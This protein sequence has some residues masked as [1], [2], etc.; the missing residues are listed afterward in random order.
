MALRPRADALPG[1]LPPP[2]FH[3]RFQAFCTG[4]L[5]LRFR[6]MGDEFVTKFPL[7]PRHLPI[8]SYAS[9][10]PASRFRGKIH[11]GSEMPV[12]TNQANPKRC[13][14]LFRNGQM[15]AL[16]APLAHPRFPCHPAPPPPRSTAPA[17]NPSAAAKPIAHL[18]TGIQSVKAPARFPH[19]QSKIHTA[20]TKQP[21]IFPNPTSNTQHPKFQTSSHSA[22][23]GKS[24]RRF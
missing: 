11:K 22:P 12:P 8:H 5:L 4:L 14:I 18:A 23:F 21:A 6:H 20:A 10:R 2:A 17:S 3:L 24:P 19:L 9:Q 7:F 13:S 16:S 1:T 15:T